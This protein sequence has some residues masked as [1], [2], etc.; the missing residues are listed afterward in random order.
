MIKD[1]LSFEDQ[2]A[3]LTTRGLSIADCEACKEFLTRAN[4][5]RF[6]GYARYFQKAP[7]QG[8]NDFEPGATFEQIRDIY[9]LDHELRALCL[10]G[11][12]LAETTL[13]TQFAHTYSAVKGPY[14]SYQQ[15]TAFICGNNDKPVTEAIFRDL[16]R[17]K[18]PYVL[19]FRKADPQNPD[20]PP[21]FSDMP[22]W[23]AVEAMSFGTLSR[24]IER[25]ADQ[26]IPKQVANGLGVAWDGFQ[27]QVKAL[28]YLRNRSAHHSRLWNHSVL[29][30]PRLPNNLRARAKRDYGQFDPRSIFTILVALDNLLTK[31]GAYASFLTDA[32]ALVDSNLAF[33]DGLTKPHLPGRPA[34]GS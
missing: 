12:A 2:V 1:H 20:A 3:L 10:R 17:S 22:I 23:A 33:R 5:Y 28:V 32:T 27:S 31:A 26:N 6:S 16:E 30:A 9:E 18:E 21:T 19:H 29:D 15:D 7:R 14:G 24:C 25:C 4:Y 34:Q 8:Q 13:R 11:L